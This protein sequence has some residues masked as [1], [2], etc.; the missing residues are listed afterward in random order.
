MI[1]PIQ[2]ASPSLS[3]TFLVEKNCRG[4]CGFFVGRDYSV[5]GA[6][7]AQSAEE[8]GGCYV[9]A[10]MQKNRERKEEKIAFLQSPVSSSSMY[11]Y[12]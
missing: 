5:T 7:T 12:R 4:Q 3:L 11:M 2:K 1:G 8:N 6:S 10:M 9:M